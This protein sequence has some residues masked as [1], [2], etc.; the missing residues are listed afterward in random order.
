LASDIHL[1]GGYL[2]EADRAGSSPSEDDWSFTGHR[3]KYG[4]TLPAW[5]KLTTALDL[6]YNFRPYDHENEFSPSSNRS[7]RRDQ[8]YLLNMT[9]SRPW[10]ERVQVVFSYLYQR[11]DSNISTF[12]YKRSVYGLLAI[13]RF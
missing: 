10:G 6:E 7:K 8:G 11:N 12:D 3:V 2:F 5:R 1:R 9:L 4:I 13:A